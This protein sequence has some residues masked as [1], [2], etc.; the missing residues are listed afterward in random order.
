M[1]IPLTPAG[2]IHTAVME[3]RVERCKRVSLLR[4]G[5]E[6]DTPRWLVGLRCLPASA[7]FTHTPCCH[8][9]QMPS[10]GHQRT[11]A[12][13]TLLDGDLGCGSGSGFVP[14]HHAARS[15]GP[16]A[17]SGV[18]SLTEGWYW[19]Q[20]LYL[21]PVASVY[22]FQFMTPT[23]PSCPLHIH[24]HTQRR[25]RS[26]VSHSLRAKGAAADTSWC[27]SC[28]SGPHRRDVQSR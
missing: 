4:L 11:S 2:S 5:R 13:H 16:C 9:P 27:E 17:S 6:E 28:D 19:R 1:M 23:L 20:L 22:E 10:T 8:C 26:T 14:S 24:T 21:P 7:P 15:S 25:N 12:S 18:V 3:M